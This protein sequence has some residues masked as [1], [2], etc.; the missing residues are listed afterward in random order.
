MSGVTVE[1]CTEKFPNV[2]PDVSDTNPPVEA[3]RA[4]DTWPVSVTL[5]AFRLSE[6]D[7]ESNVLDCITVRLVIDTGAEE[8]IGLGGAMGVITVDEVLSELGEIGSENVT[9]SDPTFM[10]IETESI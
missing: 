9:V 10:S 6:I 3:R 5:I 7:P 8:V 1:I 2:L 4:E